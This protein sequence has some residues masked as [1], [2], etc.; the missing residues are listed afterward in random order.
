[1]ANPQAQSPL[2]ASHLRLM[3]P[4]SQQT[5]SIGSPYRVGGISSVLNFLKSATHF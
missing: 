4:I 1:M 2:E 3:K 5:R